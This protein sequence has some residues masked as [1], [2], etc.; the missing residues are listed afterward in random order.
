MLSNTVDC[1]SLGLGTGK[2]TIARKMGKMFHSLGLLPCEDV[3][4]ITPKDLTTGYM[5]QTGKQVSKWLSDARGKVLFIDEAYTM[6]PVKGGQYMQEA[7]D[8]LVG[9]LTSEEY[10]GKLVVILAGYE[11]DIDDMLEANSGLRSRFSEKM[12][13]KDLSLDAAVEMFYNGLRANGLTINS[14]AE[15]RIC[16]EVQRLKDAPQFGNGRDME[17][18]VKKTFSEFARTNDKEVDVSHVAAAVQTML[19]NKRSP[20][21]APPPPREHAQARM[22]ATAS[23]SVEPRVRA[24]ARREVS[25]PAPPTEEEQEENIEEMSA[26]ASSV[27]NTPPKIGAFEKTLQKYLDDR[28]LNNQSGVKLVATASI[29]GSYLRNMAVDIAKILKISFEEAQQLLI[30]WQGDQDNVRQKLEEQEREQLRAKKE[31]RKA[32]VPIWRCAVCGQADQPFIACYVSPYI[33]RYE[34][35]DMP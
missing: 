1:C 14:H 20:G 34:E 30:K 29:D 2:T 5:G 12:F 24:T 25:A 33:V 26:A 13:F 4:E 9:G 11:D 10:K 35:V 21:N 3:V 23:A 16:A 8:C 7:V 19:S 28:G 18:L 6:N 27:E 32:L 15:E 17:S 22:Y 31:K